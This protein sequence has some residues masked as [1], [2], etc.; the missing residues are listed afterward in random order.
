MV[1]LVNHFPKLFHLSMAQESKFNNILINNY[2]NGLLMINVS[3][4][5]LP[6]EHEKDK[7]HFQV[8]PT[9]RVF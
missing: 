9:K 4:K 2:L 1:F 5:V 6:K 3:K 8:N 7:F